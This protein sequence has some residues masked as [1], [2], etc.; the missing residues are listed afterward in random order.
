MKIGMDYE[1]LIAD[2]MGYESDT[3]SA[4][5]SRIR[6]EE[7]VKIAD[8]MIEMWVENYLDGTMITLALNGVRQDHQAEVKRGVAEVMQ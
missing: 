6:R 5:G 8:R 4:T 3:F 1:D 2:I 7:A